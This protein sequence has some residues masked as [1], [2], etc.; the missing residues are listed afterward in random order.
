MLVATPGD[1]TPRT[2]PGRAVATSSA[3]L[4]LVFLAVFVSVASKMLETSAIEERVRA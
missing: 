3:C 4:S 2:S 1:I